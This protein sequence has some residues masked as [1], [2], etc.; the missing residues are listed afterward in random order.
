MR[1]RR[2]RRRIRR[3]KAGRPTGRLSETHPRY[4]G[5]TNHRFVIRNR[6]FD[7]DPALPLVGYRIL[8]DG[9]EDARGEF[10]ADPLTALGEVTGLLSEARYAP[11][12]TY[13]AEVEVYDE[14][15][16]L[17]ARDRQV[18][19]WRLGRLT[20]VWQSDQEHWREARRIRWELPM[21]PMRRPY[22]SLYPGYRPRRRWLARL[23]DW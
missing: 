11:Y 9:R 10:H 8:I 23:L 6:R 17:I 22:G 2:H 19:S 12:G 4:P 1:W 3:P 18:R 16:G 7:A 5:L 21:L 15:G 20:V 14:Q 13:M